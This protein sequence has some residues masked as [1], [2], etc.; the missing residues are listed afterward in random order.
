MVRNRDE[1]VPPLFSGLRHFKDAGGSIAPGRVHLQIATKPLFPR[2]VRFENHSRV[3]PGEKIAANRRDT[4]NL[5]AWFFDP[6]FELFR[7]KRPDSV[8]LGESAPGRVNIR[9]TFGPEESAA[10]RSP[11]RANQNARTR[12]SFAGQQFGEIGV[13]NRFDLPLPPCRAQGLAREGA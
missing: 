2:R 4:R 6:H 11:K 10:R 5:G 1:F 9:G 7:D 12:L 8:Q 13:G 3:G